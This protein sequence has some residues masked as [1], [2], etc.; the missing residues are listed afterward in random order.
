MLLCQS[1]RKTQV[2]K[3]EKKKKKVL[4]NNLDLC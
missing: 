4:D 2:E 3:L 1:C